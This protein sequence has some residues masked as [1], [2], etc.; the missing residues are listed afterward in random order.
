MI[1]MC[2]GWPA[3][4]PKSKSGARLQRARPLT[5]AQRRA[6]R[7]NCRARARK[8]AG[9]RRRPRTSSP[10]AWTGMNRLPVWPVC[11]PSTAISS[12]SLGFVLA[13]SE[14]PFLPPTASFSQILLFWTCALPPPLPHPLALHLG[15]GQAGVCQQNELRGTAVCQWNEAGSNAMLLGCNTMRGLRTASVLGSCVRLF[16]DAHDARPWQD[17]LRHGMAESSTKTS[18][19]G[20]FT[21][22]ADANKQNTARRFT[23]STTISCSPLH[24]HAP[25]AKDKYTTAPSL[26]GR[27]A[28]ARSPLLMAWHPL[29]ALKPGEM[30]S[31]NI[32]NTG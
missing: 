16:C 32:Q 24:L 27:D 28:T 14:N 2:C 19:K 25:L 11:F 13:S 5:I 22:A 12:P 21:H 29:Q 10:R 8:Q 31:Q 4:Q 15:D 1:G 9:T 17:L 23:A 18:T 30:S 26:V 6:L 20:G 7:L 3:R